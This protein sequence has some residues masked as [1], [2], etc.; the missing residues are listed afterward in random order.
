[1]DATRPL[2]CHERLRDEP[3]QR[4]RAREAV[5]HA[6][7]MLAAGAKAWTGALGASILVTQSRRL[8]RRSPKEFAE[9]IMSRVSY[10]EDIEE[11]RYEDKCRR[12]APRPGLFPA[13]SK[14]GYWW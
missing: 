1:M 13:C 7:L 6:V 3:G 8:F 14:G 9:R 2:G 5:H 11:R 4:E 12:D 10:I